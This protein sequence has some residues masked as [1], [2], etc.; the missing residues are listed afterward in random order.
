MG[1]NYLSIP[2]LQRLHYNGCNYLS[3]LGLK[4]NHVSK[5]GPWYHSWSVWQAYTFF[6]AHAL[7]SSFSRG[8]SAGVQESF[9]LHIGSV[10]TYLHRPHYLGKRSWFLDEA[11]QFLS[12]ESPIIASLPVLNKT[13]SWILCVQDRENVNRHLRL[14]SGYISWD[15]L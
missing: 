5:R 15:I 8:Y 9:F 13:V 3:T 10:T 1:W 2:K 4:L 12:I 11:E 6:S 7:T 14:H